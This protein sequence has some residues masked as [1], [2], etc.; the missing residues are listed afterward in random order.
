MTIKQLINDLNSYYKNV[1]YDNILYCCDGQNLFY[2]YDIVVSHKQCIIFYRI[3]EDTIITPRILVSK[4]RKY[5]Y[6]QEWPILFV[7]IDTND[8]YSKETSTC[9]YNV[10]MNLRP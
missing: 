9:N 7:N 5:Q 10:I 8:S 2:I 6:Q 1:C 3:E 4:L